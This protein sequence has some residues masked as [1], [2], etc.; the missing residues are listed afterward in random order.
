MAAHAASA[1]QLHPQL[2]VTPTLI[3]TDL[4]RETMRTQVCFTPKFQIIVIVNPFVVCVRQPSRQISLHCCACSDETQPIRVEFIAFR[5]E[6][7]EQ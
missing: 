2:P 5:L 4:S 1:W 3:L 7:R 6:E